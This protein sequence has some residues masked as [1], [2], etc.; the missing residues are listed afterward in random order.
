MHKLDKITNFSFWEKQLIFENVDLVVVGSGIVGL[1]AAIS[2]K[3]LFKKAKVVVLEKGILPQGASTKNAGFSCFGSVS[4]L[5]SDLKTT[6]DD[7]VWN[8]VKMRI[9]GLHLLRKRLGDKHIDYLEYGGYELFDSE[10]KYDESKEQINKFNK[11]LKPITETKETYLIANKSIKEFGF[12]NVCGLILNTKEGQIDTGMMMFNLLKLASELGVIILNSVDVNAIN[13]IKN[14]VVIETSLGEIS[15]KKCIV[16]TN[17]LTK[18]LLPIK[19]LKPARAQVLIT[20]PIKNLKI[21]GTF[22]Y[23]EGYNYFRNINGRLL[24]GGGR[25]LDFDK[26]TTTEFALNLK[27]QK[28]LDDLLK[29]VILPSTKYEVDYRW[30]GIM[31][32]GSEKKPIIKHIS[33]NVVCAVRMGGMG[34]A[35]G[36]LVGDLAVKECCK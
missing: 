8:T 21:K 9:D 36:S 18:T 4:E 26:E 1:S 13:D 24:L 14:K 25:N 15:A 12:K 29:Q 28:H 6:K 33:P 23:N 19:D 34:V 16:C 17:G 5:I 32:V 27:I 2:Y 7:E 20:K 3:Q 35:I 30:S 22:H 10:T 11:I 31:G